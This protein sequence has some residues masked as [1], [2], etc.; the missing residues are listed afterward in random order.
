MPSTFSCAAGRR[1]GSKDLTGNPDP[2]YSTPQV[3]SPHNAGEIGSLR[4]SYAARN[5]CRGAM[6]SSSC[7]D[8]TSRIPIGRKSR[9]ENSGWPK[10]TIA[11]KW[12]GHL[13]EGVQA[14]RAVGNGGETSNRFATMS[15]PRKSN[16]GTIVPIAERNLGVE[17][18]RNDRD[19]ARKLIPARPP[20][21][22]R[23]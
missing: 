14:V 13:F 9:R 16:R 19:G 5:R 2:K 22:A 6:K 17:Q 3:G 1:G 8:D 21:S 7:P 11:A 20:P 10:V 4:K 15:L 23:R 18:R 12:R